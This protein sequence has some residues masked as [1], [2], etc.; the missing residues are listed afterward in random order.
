[1]LSM[2]SYV[3]I[4]TNRP[5]GTLYIGVTS[6]L[7]KRVYE[8]KTKLLKGFTEKYNLDKLVYYEVF[9][10]IDQAIYREKCMKEWKR[11]WKIKRI[12]EMNRDWIDLYDEVVA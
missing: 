1:M 9:E 12:E 6:D 2:P 11:E 5:N 8:H 3:Y 4:M 7:V 10:D